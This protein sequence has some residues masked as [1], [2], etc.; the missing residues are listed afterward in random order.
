MTKKG[1]VGLVLIIVSLLAV[2]GGLFFVGGYRVAFFAPVDKMLAQVGVA[3]GVAPNP[4]NSLN[5]QLNEKQLQIDEEQSDLTAQEAA[6]ASSTEESGLLAASPVVWYLMI[7]VGVLTFLVGLNFFLDWRRT[8]RPE[9][10][11]QTL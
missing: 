10:P 9:V 8:E 3:V 5:E 6:F 4:Y 7:A 1:G 11:P 2:G